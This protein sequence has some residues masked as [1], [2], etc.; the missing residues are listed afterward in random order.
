MNDNLK[1]KAA[2]AALSEIRDG[3]YNPLRKIL[4]DVLQNNSSIDLI[5]LKVSVGRLKDL[6][7]QK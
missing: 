1:L 7:D 2:L 4:T 6:I 3:I 5:S